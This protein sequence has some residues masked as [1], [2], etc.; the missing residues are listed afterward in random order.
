MENFI[1]KLVDVLDTEEEITMQ[2]N[3]SDIEEWDSLGA[4]SFIAMASSVYGK[5]IDA[6][7]LRHAETVQD[8]YDLVK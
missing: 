8:L 3:L 5:K 6:V 4:V 2:T 7:K 1:E